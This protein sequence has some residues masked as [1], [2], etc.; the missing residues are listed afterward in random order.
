MSLPIAPR[1][2]GQRHGGVAPLRGAVRRTGVELLIWSSRLLLPVTLCVH[3]LVAACA[4]AH[5]AAAALV[6]LCAPGL[7]EIFWLC[8][9]DLRTGAGMIVLY[10]CL[11]VV[12]V[13]AGLGMGM[14]M[15][16]AGQAAPDRPR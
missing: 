16:G 7:A 12:L 9:L 3:V 4:M 6:T 15:M 5:G 8:S 14:V 11:A 10:G 13:I 2:P 1:L